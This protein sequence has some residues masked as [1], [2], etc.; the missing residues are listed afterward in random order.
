MLDMAQ[1]E[2]VLQV[3]RDRGL[4][5]VSYAGF[6]FISIS[7]FLR[8]SGKIRSKMGESQKMM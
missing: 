2:L 3:W 7:L 8:F 5:T 6:G 1:C 4:V